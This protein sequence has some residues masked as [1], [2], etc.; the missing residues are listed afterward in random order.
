MA[1]GPCG[2]SSGVRL[3]S[4]G[5]GLF[6]VA[7]ALPSLLTSDNSAAPMVIAFGAGGNSG[8]LY[9]PLASIVPS[10]AF[11]PATPFT[12]QFT[13]GFD[14]SPDFALYC[15]CAVPAMVAPIGVTVNA[16]DPGPSAPP[17]GRIAS[18]HPPSN[19]ANP[20]T[21]TSKQPFTIPPGTFFGRGR[22]RPRCQVLLESL[23]TYGRTGVGRVGMLT[24]SHYCPCGQIQNNCSVVL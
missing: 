8:A 20:V 11:P 2:T 24:V 13:L 15:W 12:D 3:E 16:V 1:N 17:P 23:R 22:T 10:T 5:T 21:N 4:C 14:P 9:N 18:A 19:T 6:S 7:P